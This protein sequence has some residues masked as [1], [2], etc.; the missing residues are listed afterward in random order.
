M[1]SA[2]EAF[3]LE[4]TAE[5]SLSSLLTE[6][7]SSDRKVK[8]LPPDPGHQN[9]A[10]AQM[11]VN[12]V[13]LCTCSLGYHS[14]GGYHRERWFRRVRRLLGA[15][16]RHLQIGRTTMQGL[17]FYD[18]AGTGEFWKINVLGEM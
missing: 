14:V 10:I 5:K 9:S 16:F 4:T 11:C 17:L 15:G 13:T 18:S 6:R 12:H 2:A 8:P 7:R 1:R 3:T